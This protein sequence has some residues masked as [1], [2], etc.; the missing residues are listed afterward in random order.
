MTAYRFESGKPLT[1]V[2][3]GDAAPGDQSGLVAEEIEAI[4]DD[5]TRV[6]LSVFRRGDLTLN[7]HALALISAY[8]GYG[9][10]MTPSFSAIWNEW[11][12]AGHVD[13][14]CHT[15]G[16]GEKGEAWRLGGSGANKQRGVEDF[17]ACSRELEKRGYSTS[18]RT[19]GISASMGGVLVGGAYTTPGS[20]FGAMLIEVGE[21]NP[22]RLLAAK[23]GAEQIAE[24]G[25]P[26]TESGLKQLAAM[27]PVQRVK[28]GE[29]YPPLLLSVGLSDALVAPWNSGKFA[30][31]V[32][33]ASPSTPVW[34][35]TEEGAGHVATTTSA[36]AEKYANYYAWAEATLS[37]DSAR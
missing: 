17:I 2:G 18:A 23:D 34:I 19:A 13:A 37:P 20:A 8:G 16:G 10:S 11:S 33:A 35:R 31:T 21:L 25:D 29:H 3:L 7:G 30:A 36:T 1:D 27:D 9:A 4:S 28:S 15:R 5:G 14:I 6:P 22:S 24:V 12:K 26:R 32:M